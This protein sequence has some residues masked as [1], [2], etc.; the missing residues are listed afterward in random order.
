MPNQK[1]AL[2]RQRRLE[3]YRIKHRAGDRRIPIDCPQCG[4]KV[5]IPFDVFRNRVQSDPEKMETYWVFHGLS[6]IC[7]SCEYRIGFTS[8]RDDKDSDIKLDMESLSLLR[9][10]RMS[11]NINSTEEPPAT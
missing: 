2:K 8:F 6:W 1:R 5:G 9:L 4:G 7:E 3:N 11:H 10:S